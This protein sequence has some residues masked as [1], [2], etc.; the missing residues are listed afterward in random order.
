MNIEHNLSFGSADIQVRAGKSMLVMLSVRNDNNRQVVELPLSIAQC[1]QLR[2]SLNAAL[3]IVR[4][5][6]PKDVLEIE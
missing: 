1:E 5:N 4:A 6:S 3:G 2:N